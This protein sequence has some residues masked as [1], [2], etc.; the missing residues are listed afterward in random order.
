MYRIGSL[1]M[2]A[3]LAACG[4]AKAQDNYP[5]QTVKFVLPS[6]PG[7]TNPSQTN[8]SVSV[9]ISAARSTGKGAA[10]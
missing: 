3:L 1:A 4:V 5:T 10:F 9:Q 7:S 2:A 8:P 6:A